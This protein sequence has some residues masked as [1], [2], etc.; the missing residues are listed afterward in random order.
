MSNYNY[1]LFIDDLNSELNS[2][3]ENL[4]S[5][6]E[7]SNLNDIF[8][9]IS[10]NINE[11][12]NLEKKCIKN[13]TEMIDFLAKNFGEEEKE[14]KENQTE[15]KTE[16]EIKSENSI[17]IENKC[18]DLILR[19]MN[20]PEVPIKCDTE[21]MFNK[22][23]KFMALNCH[24]D[25]VQDKKKNKIFL[26]SNDCKNN[27]DCVKLLYLLS[28]VNLTNIKLNQTEIEYI[29][30]KTKEIQDK[31]AKIKNTFVYKW[32]ILNTI[33]Q[34]YYMNIFKKGLRNKK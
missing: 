33:Q 26:Y 31:Q 24:P 13:N 2:N 21:K 12:Y 5:N 18:T 7:N 17:K 27:L 23:F 4:N 30:E 15:S 3:F 29:K 16:S 25:K 19:D 10:N 1:T 14:E 22:L 32:D 20:I 28:T 6:F 8:I 9:D 11:L 34:Y